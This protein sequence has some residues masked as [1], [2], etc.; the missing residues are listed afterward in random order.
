MLP[1]SGEPLAERVD[2]RGALAG[3]GNEAIRDDRERRL[4]GDYAG[5]LRDHAGNRGARIAEVHAP[6][7]IADEASPLGEPG[8]DYEYGDEDYQALRLGH[9]PTVRGL[10]EGG[11][12]GGCSNEA[13][14]RYPE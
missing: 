6:G 1:V 7:L 5:A 4:V 2:H 12:V 13:S 9:H 14:R 10:P 11:P 8:G 3:I